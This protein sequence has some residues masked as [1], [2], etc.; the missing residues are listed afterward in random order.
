M[1]RYSPFKKIEKTVMTRDI[2]DKK[3]IWPFYERMIIEGK[4]KLRILTKKDIEEVSELWRICYG[5]LYGS[6]LKYEWV[7]Y[8]EKYKEK[9]AIK[10]KW[11]NDSQNKDFCM[12]LFEDT[13]NFN[14]VGAWTLWKDDRNLQIEFSIGI[15]HPDFRGKKYGISIVSASNDY[16]RVLEKESGAEYL[17]AFCETWHNTTQF[18]CFKRWGF[19]VGGIFPGQFTRWNGNQTEYRTCVVHFYKFIG[20]VEKYVTQPDEWELLPE[21]KN[22]WIVLKR[23]N[24][25][26][27]DLIR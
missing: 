20:D 19:K 23:V 18:L 21:F 16:I 7:L 24:E 9:V 4:V 15:I 11:E 10:E 6:S 14:I 5:E 8:P 25:C 17:T 27:T 3:V 13:E 26:S 1:K 12:L 22:L 2:I